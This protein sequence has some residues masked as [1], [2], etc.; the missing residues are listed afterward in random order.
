[1]QES[2]KQEME[3]D[4]AIIQALETYIPLQANMNNEDN[5]K[6]RQLTYKSKSGKRKVYFV[7]IWKRYYVIIFDKYSQSDN[8]DKYFYDHFNLN[9]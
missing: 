6:K 1:N 7:V 4:I 3:E 5:E 9:Q 2:R 8:N